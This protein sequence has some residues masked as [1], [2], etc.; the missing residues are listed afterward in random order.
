MFQILSI[1][2]WKCFYQ[3]FDQI[4][5][6]YLK[7]PNPSWKYKQY[8]NRISTKWNAEGVP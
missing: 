5:N 7:I 4:I 3:K 6:I 8:V 2:V 1:G